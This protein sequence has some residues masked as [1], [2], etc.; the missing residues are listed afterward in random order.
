MERC[1]VTGIEML[2]NELWADHCRVRVL[3]KR[4]KEKGKQRIEIL[5]EK[6]N[7]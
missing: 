6:Q 5:M 2:D 7:T 4:E 3:I 1:R